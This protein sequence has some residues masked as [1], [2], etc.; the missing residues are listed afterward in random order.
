[1]GNQ[2]G[3]IRLRVTPIRGCAWFDCTNESVTLPPP[4]EL[5]ASILEISSPFL[6][7]LGHVSSTDHPLGGQW[8]YLAQRHK[9]GE[10][11][12]CVYSERPSDTKSAH[13]T[14]TGCANVVTLHN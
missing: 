7:M 4:F 11:I 3:P 9:P 6:P 10:C 5:D 13:P 14:M 2:G 12:L 1:M 8:V